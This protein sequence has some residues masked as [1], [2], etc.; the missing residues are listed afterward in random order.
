MKPIALAVLLCLTAFP[1]EAGYY[2]Y[3][4]NWNPYHPLH[5]WH[6]PGPGYYNMYRYGFRPNG[7][8]FGRCYN[9]YRCGW[10]Y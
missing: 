3:K 4:F 5:S 9:P 2:G 10:G 7:G 8:G 1:S 6:A